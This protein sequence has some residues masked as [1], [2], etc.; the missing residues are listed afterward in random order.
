MRGLEERSESEYTRMRIC[1]HAGRF[2]S[3]PAHQ[4][5]KPSYYSCRELVIPEWIHS[6]NWQSGKTD[7]VPAEGQPPERRD[8]FRKMR[9]VWSIN[10]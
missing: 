9:L 8:G 3:G 7:A 6:I 10:K 1:R 2:D 4:K 5:E